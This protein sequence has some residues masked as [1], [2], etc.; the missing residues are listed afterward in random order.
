MTLQVAQEH[1]QVTIKP[2]GKT[3]GLLPFQIGDSLIVKFYQKLVFYRDLESVKDK[4]D[5]VQRYVENIKT[6]MS[7]FKNSS[8]DKEL[9]NYAQILET[10]AHEISKKFKSIVPHSR[11]RRGLIN[12]L[13]SVFKS[14]SGNLDA[15][16][17]IRYDE[18]ISAL[19]SNQAKLQDNFNKQISVSQKMISKFNSTLSIIQQNEQHLSNKI[20]VIAF[21]EGSAQNYN[22][23]KILINH[24]INIVQNVKFVLLEIEDSIN[25]ARL[26]V[27]DTSII[28]PEI[29]I[30]ELEKLSSNISLPIK[31]TIENLSDLEKI[32]KTNAYIL[33]YKLTFILN[34]PVVDLSPFKTFHLFSIPKMTNGSYMAIIPRKKYLLKYLERNIF[35]DQ[36]KCLILSRKYICDYTP[37]DEIHEES[38][39]SQIVDNKSPSKCLLTPV[40][41]RRNLI[42]RVADTNFWIVVPKNPV[43]IVQDCDGAITSNNI[44]TPSLVS[45]HCST[46]IDGKPVTSNPL[47]NQNYQP[48]IFSHDINIH[49]NKSNFVVS[50][51][52]IKEI[53]LDEL[54]DLQ[55]ELEDS[56][57]SL[58][59][60]IHKH[61]GWM[62]P[63]Y[64][65]IT[66][67]ITFII[68][69]KIIKPKCQRQ[70]RPN[71]D[72]ENAT[73]CL[74]PV[75]PRLPF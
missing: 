48:W 5:A 44:G 10:S 59:E 40:K 33:N 60:P 32:I 45:P 25:F 24:L 14:I 53:Q 57:T 18:A 26:N 1:P 29:L 54:Q 65:I 62:L 46:L 38:C 27:I 64:V 35:D 20:D 16:D 52:T 47:Y 39:E 50:P 74:G 72:G 67:F 9:S 66:I 15:N 36:L 43:P 41:L 63:P 55:A 42:Q 58:E 75:D 19:N 71:Q 73:E 49:L 22:K 28:D 68:W 4:I 31:P 21:Y 6:S 30:A 37:E 34:I 17:G 13:G 23:I 12:G 69:K 7:Y 56:R 2:L 11:T 3:L 61:P 8:Y 51:D 70:V